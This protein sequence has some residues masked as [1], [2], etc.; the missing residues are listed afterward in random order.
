MRLYDIHKQ[1]RPLATDQDTSQMKHIGTLY[2]ICCDWEIFQDANG[3]YW[4]KGD[5]KL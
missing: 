5:W 4:T 2:L 1:A 3:I